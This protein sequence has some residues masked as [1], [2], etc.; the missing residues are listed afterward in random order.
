MSK[1]LM[2]F[3][4]LLLAI[5]LMVP[6]AWAATPTTKP[7]RVGL[8]Y[9]SGAL[10]VAN[11]ENNTGAGAGYRFGYYD[12]NLQFHELGRTDQSTTKLTMLKT[13]NIWVNG[14][15][16]AT[17]NNGGQV[18][19]CYHIQVPGNYTDYTQA[20]QAAAPLGGFVAWMDGSFQVRVGAYATQGEAEAAIAAGTVSGTVVGTSAYG[21]N[22][23]QTGSAQIL[24]QFDGGA[25]LSLGV[26]PDVTGSSTVRTWFKGYRYEGGFRYER[27][28]GGNL[29]VVNILDLES[30]IKGVVPYEMSNNWPLEALKAQAICARS[31]AYNNILNAKH[32]KYHFDV[33][34]TTDCQV[35][36]GAGSN[37]PTYQ[38]TETTD[39]AV[40][41]TAGQ[42]AWY[43]NQII[44]AF[45][46]SSHGGASESVYHVW[47]SSL[48]Q[49]P[50]L[51]GVVDPYE[52]E[53]AS[54]N[55]YSSWDI[56]YT[57]SELTKR[58]QSYGYGNGTQ[59]Q[60]LEL[61]YSDL[62]NVIKLTVRYV[63]GQSNTF[64]PDKIRSIFGVPSI[65]FTMA[66]GKTAAT[67]QTTATQQPLV[68]QQTQQSSIP[69][70]G[71][72]GLDRSG[73]N[74]V[75]SGSGVVSGLDANNSYLISGTGTVEQLPTTQPPEIPEEP[76]EP[77]EPE[78]PEHPE[79]NNPTGTTVTVS[80]GTYTF[81][82]SGYG[83]QLGMSQYGAW[84]MVNLG[85]TYK[86][87]VE[88]YFPGTQVK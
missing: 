45:Y 8:A 13:Q 36:C 35:Y 57:T 46:S 9:G 78:H 25:D 59:V 11:L 18:I 72:N 51:C 85:Y 27:I 15:N 54:K 80:N 44:E 34:T 20:S 38:A 81:Q 75:L 6:S 39:R 64:K 60:S 52:Q 43:G 26:L 17:S 83:H 10:A 55:A 19:G 1:K 82:G 79:Q 77:E 49:Y 76:E 63:N 14:S 53:I 4:A 3:V 88:F 23:T 22:V 37:V 67:R 47:G 56:S 16:Y 2:Q 42:Y 86:Q 33:C 12:A 7:I 29:T 87:I 31:Y 71:G 62:G 84:A 69:I 70:N 48:S 40:E 21:V 73:N 50:Y 24:F 32:G 58:L 5:C 65:R 61:T 74:F 30:Y 66:S 68:T 28:D 41:E